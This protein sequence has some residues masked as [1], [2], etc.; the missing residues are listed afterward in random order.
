[1]GEDYIS[2]LCY[3]NGGCG[4][5]IVVSQSRTAKSCSPT[6]SGSLF[7]YFV[8]CVFVI[9]WIHC[10][11]IP[12]SASADSFTP[13]ATYDTASPIYMRRCEYAV[14]RIQLMGTRMGPWVCLFWLGIFEHL[15]PQFLGW[16]WAI[17]EVEYLFRDASRQ[18]RWCR[19]K[20]QQWQYCQH[21]QFATSHLCYKMMTCWCL[22][23]QCW[24]V[25]VVPMLGYFVRKHR[26]LRREL[27]CGVEKR[28]RSVCL[29]AEPFF[30]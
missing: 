2:T 13:Y 22:V 6:N 18:N 10:E 5:R 1:M 14:S 25:L 20:W 30:R 24:F 3:R 16:H 9:Q 23:A 4:I 11:W 15:L 8:V 28:S 7:A 27:T 12:P 29:S 17:I 26:W 19:R 21:S